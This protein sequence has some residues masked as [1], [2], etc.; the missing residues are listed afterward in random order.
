MLSP[1]YTYSTEATRALPIP[2]TRSLITN[3]YP[4][5]QA[6]PTNPTPAWRKTAMDGHYCEKYFVYLF[7]D[8][9]PDIYFQF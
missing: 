7:A 8:A 3:V 5:S 4:G 9:R 2:N 6:V 1:P